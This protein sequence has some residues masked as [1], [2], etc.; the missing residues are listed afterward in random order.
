MSRFD[1]V[2]LCCKPN[3]V[4]PL[5]HT[6]TTRKAPLQKS[7]AQTRFS[8]HRC[9]KLPPPLDTIQY[10]RLGRGSIIM[11]RQIPPPPQ[12]IRQCTP[13]R[14]G[15]M[16]SWNTKFGHG[17][18]QISSLTY[19][20]SARPKLCIICHFRKRRTQ[21]AEANLVAHPLARVHSQDS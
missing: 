18:L 21:T 12:Q 20:D 10:C 16:L 7:C 14:S 19:H 8:N 15:L 2:T 4:R 6:I 11:P 3:F 13:R 17:R 1:K 5:V 9:C